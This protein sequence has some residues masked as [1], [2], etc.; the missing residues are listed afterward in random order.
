M[1]RLKDIRKSKSISQTKL[2]EIS[3]VN[4][5]RKTGQRERVRVRKNGGKTKNESEN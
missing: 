5:R 2:A 1:S 3:G 4:L